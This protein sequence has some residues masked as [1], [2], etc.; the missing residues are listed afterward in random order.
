MCVCERER[1]SLE[2]LCEFS[3]C[4][5]VHTSAYTDHVCPLCSPAPVHEV[6][7]PEEIKSFL[8]D[9]QLMLSNNSKGCFL[10]VSPEIPRGK[11]S[12]FSLADV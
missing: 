5:C 11:Y 2:C 3:M 8:P 4:V 6:P 7:Y 10:V 12:E 9:P 1:E